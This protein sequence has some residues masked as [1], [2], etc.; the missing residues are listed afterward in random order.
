MRGVL[1][2][3]TTVQYV[4]MRENC[5]LGSLCVVKETQHYLSAASHL[6][7]PGCANVFKALGVSGVQS[8]TLSYKLQLLALSATKDLIMDRALDH[9]TLSMG[10]K[11]YIFKKK[12]NFRY[13]HF[14]LKFHIYFVSTKLSPMHSTELRITFKKCFPHLQNERNSPEY[15][16]PK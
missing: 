2:L 10:T 12:Y 7:S 16:F 14:L 9:G 1:D 6:S 11:R 5:A 13:C 4:D 3:D 15:S 8:E